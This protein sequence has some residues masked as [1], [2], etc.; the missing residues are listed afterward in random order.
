[1]TESQWLTSADPVAMLQQLELI[2]PRCQGESGV[3]RI[4]DRKL[5]LFACACCR[6]LGSLLTDVQRVRIVL[7]EKE[8]WHQA[9]SGSVHAEYL[10]Q[11]AITEYA[12]T[13]GRERCINYALGWLES[14]NAFNVASQAP[15][16]LQ[17]L[18]DLP[19]Q[20]ILLRDIIGNPYHPMPL[21]WAQGAPVDGELEPPYCPWFTPTV[22]ALA[23]NAYDERL[24]RKCRRC[25]GSGRM[26]KN[27][28]DHRC[29]DCHGDGYT[30]DG[31]IDPDRL[32]VLADALEEAGA[33]EEN[34]ADL[35][36]HLRGVVGCDR[37]EGAGT[38]E[39]SSGWEKCPSC[40]GEGLVPPGPHV[41]GCWALD[42]IL[43]KE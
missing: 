24:V 12:R 9:A 18:V 3:G 31:I 40:K 39:I 13:L 25:L 33:T 11:D 38:V 4:N 23:Q 35:L 10:A 20:A 19:T 36:W 41:R 17:M 22:L 21:P 14:V 7:A 29:G 15:A 30:F 1:M 34:A 37:C 32:A 27:G 43:G 8:P 28:S 26:E 42:L 5:R 2:G 6:A 16:W